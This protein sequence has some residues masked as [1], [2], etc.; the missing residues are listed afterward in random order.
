MV[1]TRREV[2]Q[3]ANV[4]LRTVSNVVNGFPSVAP[5]T[6]ERVL[7]VIERLD[8]RPSEIARM[9]KRGRSG[10]IAL[11]LPELDTPY[12]AELT[13]AFVE[14]GTARGYTVV[15]DQ[16]D[17][18]VA[19]E[20][21]LIN[22]TDRGSLFDGL[23]VSPLGLRPEHM[24][25]ISAERPVVFLGEDTHSG[26]DQVMIDNVAAA[27][28]A[29]SHLIGLDRT[30]IAAIGADPH[31]PASS[32]I[33]LAGYQAALDD[34]GIAID[35]KLIG[36]VNAFRRHDGA[37]AMSHLLDLDHPPDAVFCFSDPL[38]LGALRTLHE[39]GIRV[40]EDIAVV[41]F[42]DIEDGRYSTP[43]LSSISPD[44]TYIASK[45]LDLLTARLDGTFEPPRAYFAPFEL[46]IRES[47]PVAS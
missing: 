40:P 21:E 44:K 41:G 16:T 17:G 24:Q 46:K 19:R 26:F 29:V 18:D 22:Q 5:D 28:T 14:L 4:S 45:A 34:A 2:A 9:L 38:A 31:R 33:R 30:R 15:I 8:Y 20:L 7:R 43:T 47:S 1:A 32:T 42:D 25:G 27:R 12:F 6:R 11:L 13:R 36:Y 3:A 23:I 37:S 39:R 10:L 35:P